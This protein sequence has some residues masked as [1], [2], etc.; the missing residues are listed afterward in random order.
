M[1]SNSSSLKA[2]LEVNPARSQLEKLLNLRAS[3]GEHAQQGSSCLRCQLVEVVAKPVPPGVDAMSDLASLFKS[4]QES[5]NE[6]TLA[7]GVCH[8]SL[9]ASSHTELAL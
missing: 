8:H 3:A 1:P 7:A 9:A 5:F 6:P 2:C 4:S